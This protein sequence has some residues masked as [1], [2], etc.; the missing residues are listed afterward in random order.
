MGHFTC[1]HILRHFK[2][3][4]QNRQDSI[5]ITMDNQHR[6]MFLFRGFGGVQHVK[7]HTNITSLQGKFQNQSRRRAQIRRPLTS[8]P[9]IKQRLRVATRLLLRQDRQAI[10][11]FQ[12]L[13]SKSIFR[14]VIMSS[15]FRVLFHNIRITRRLTFSTTIL[16]QN[17]RVSRFNRLSILNH[18]ITIRVFITR[19]IINV[20][21][22]I[23]S[24]V[25]YK[26]N[27]IH[28]ITTIFA[29]VFIQGIRTMNSIRVRRSALRIHQHVVGRRLFRKLTIFQRILSVI[30]P[31][32]RMRCISTYRHLTL[33]TFMSMLH[34]AGG[35][36]SYVTQGHLE[37]SSIIG[38][39]SV[40]RSRQLL[41]Q[42]VR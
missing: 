14:S 41:D 7:R 9:L 21:R 26:R 36:A 30:V 10:H 4:L 3:L 40:L 2:L 19:I 38:Y 17:S 5:T 15:L 1:F 28:T 33:V 23:T 11:R 27:S 6:L 32:T 39:F 42:Q 37:L 12:G 8:M 18:L 16:I 24:Q 25:P 13:L 22:G 20:S 31:S 34:A 35:M 29:Q